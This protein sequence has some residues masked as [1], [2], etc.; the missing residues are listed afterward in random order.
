FANSQKK[1]KR[2]EVL[3]FGMSAFS[4][5]QEYLQYLCQVQKYKPD[6]VLVVYH[7]G[8]LEENIPLSTDGASVCRPTFVLDDKNNLVLDWSNFHYW[9]VGERAKRYIAFDSLRR[10]SRIW[11]VLT[12]LEGS[13]TADKSLARIFKLLEKPMTPLWN[14]YL[15]NLPRHELKTTSLSDLDPSYKLATVKPEAKESGSQASDNVTPNS[16]PSPNLA[17]T[18]PRKPTA[19]NS[20]S[21]NASDAIAFR[22]LVSLQNSRWPVTEAI[23]RQFNKACNHNGTKFAVAGLPAPN[24]SF[25]YFG[26]LK[27]LKKQ[28]NIDNF[29]FIDVNTTFPQLDP[30][31]E[32]PLFLRRYHFSKAGHKLVA[33]TLLKGL[34]LDKLIN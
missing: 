25:L 21:G 20:I 24:N 22:S 27:L 11:G 12:R 2:F 14:L 28:A 15:A 3:N 34:V 16:S 8:D 17:A 13:L 26:Q 23:L 10:N 30:M 7:Y 32:S 4:T 9:L 29:T 1:T 33:D 31:Q 18:H 19:T 5:G 6:I